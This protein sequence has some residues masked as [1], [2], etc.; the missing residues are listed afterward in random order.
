[1]VSNKELKEKYSSVS[2]GCGCGPHSCA[3]CGTGRGAR[4]PAVFRDIYLY[5][6][7]VEPTCRAGGVAHTGR[8]YGLWMAPRRPLPPACML[9]FP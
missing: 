4:G 2:A 5:S 9:Q 6:A 8:P 7:I 3:R 1:M